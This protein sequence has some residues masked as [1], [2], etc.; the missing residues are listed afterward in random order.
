MIEASPT[1]WA[2]IEVQCEDSAW[3]SFSLQRETGVWKSTGAESG[4]NGTKAFIAQLAQ[5]KYEGAI[6]ESDAIYS[7]KDSLLALRPYWRLKWT[8][9]DSTSTN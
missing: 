1:Q 5:T 9:E 6:V 4:T 8:L 3:P 2:R 7:R